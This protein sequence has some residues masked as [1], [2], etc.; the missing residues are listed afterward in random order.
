MIKPWVLD[1]GP[2][3]RL[4]HPN[5]NEKVSLWLSAELE[6]GI[7]IVIPEIIDYEV[8]RSLLLEGLTRSLAR[9]DQLKAGLIY[10]PLTTAVMLKASQLWAEARK[11]G[12]VTSDPH[13]LDIDVILAAQT[14]QIDGRVATENVRHLSQLVDAVRWRT[15][16]T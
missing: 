3:G 14:L 13:A 1:S 7:P 6:R 4:A 2:L 8:R 16:H 5:P 15:A 10:L 12:F 9:L 11:R